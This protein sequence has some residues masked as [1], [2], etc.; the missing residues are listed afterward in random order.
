MTA[1]TPLTYDAETAAA[2]MG[3]I[4]T[5][6]WLKKRA[7]A[8]KIPHLKSGRGTGRAGRV[9]FTEAHMAEIVQQLEVRPVDMPAPSGPEGFTSVVTRRRPA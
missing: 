6:D 4:V 8:D 7:A 9:A 5:A 1:P 2:R 3:H